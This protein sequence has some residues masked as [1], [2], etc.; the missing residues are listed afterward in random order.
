MSFENMTTAQKLA[1]VRKRT[2]FIFISRL[3]GT[4]DYDLTLNLY[5]IH[6]WKGYRQLGRVIRILENGGRSKT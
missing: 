5:F 3:N 2:C 6:T 1:Y 4:T